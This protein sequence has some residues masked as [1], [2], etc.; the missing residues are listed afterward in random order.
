[1][2]RFTK[3]HGCG[4]DFV[5]VEEKDVA[6]F[7][8]DFPELARSMCSRRIG[9]GADGLIIVRE[10]PLE[11]MIYNSDGSRAP[12]CGNGIRCFAQYCLLEG[13]VPIT[14]AKFAVETLA[15]QMQVQVLSRDPFLVEIEVGEPIWTAA[16]VGIDT[17]K[18]AEQVDVSQPF[19]QKQMEVLGRTISVSSLFIGTIHT[20]IWVGEKGSLGVESLAKN[21]IWTKTSAVDFDVD[22][23]VIRLGRELSNSPVFGE[24][25]NVNFAQVLDANTVRLITYE[26]GAGLTAAC[27]TGACAVLALGL[28]EGKLNSRC[29]ILLPYGTLQIR[30]EEGRIYMAGPSEK[31]MQGNY[32]VAEQKG[33]SHG[34]T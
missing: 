1:L 30:Q 11:M 17:T 28:R 25:T 8:D 18:Y 20:V 34:R 9:I 3:Y 24:K 21:P 27:G 23:E 5:I 32:F 29:E 15:G 13:I 6:A 2:I 12:M 14:E 31:I 33:Q 7:S 22:E 10:N 19:L 26:R 4:N 16:A